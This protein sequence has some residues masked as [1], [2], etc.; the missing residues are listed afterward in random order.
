M[1][2]PRL[3]YH[4]AMEL[5]NTNDVRNTTLF[6]YK[7]DSP[8]GAVAETPWAAPPPR[9]PR[10]GAHPDPRPRAYVARCQTASSP[11][12]ALQ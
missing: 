2:E 8:H 4:R 6:L 1:D 9:C 3:P 7:L 5:E 10:P 11:A 12:P